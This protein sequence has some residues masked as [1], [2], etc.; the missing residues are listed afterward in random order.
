MAQGTISNQNGN[1]LTE[2]I[3]ILWVLR[4]IVLSSSLLGIPFYKEVFY[5]V[6]SRVDG[7]RTVSQ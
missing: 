4:T 1:L 6:S 2:C 3:Q 5:A 7:S